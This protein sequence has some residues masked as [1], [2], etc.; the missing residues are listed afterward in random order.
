MAARGRRLAWLLLLFAAV[1][2]GLAGC[3]TLGYYAQ[4]VGGHL[5]LMRRARPVDEWLSD[6]ATPAKLRER[7]LLT[8]QIRDFAVKELK[9]P[10]NRSYR[11]YADLGRGS[12]VWN[13]VATPELSLELKRWCFPV[14]GC[15]G[16]RGYFDRAAAEALAKS[17]KD[18]GLDVNVYGVPAYSTLGW[19]NW[20]GGDP[21]LNTFIDWPEAQLARLVF[22]ELAHQVAYAAGDTTF[23]E[24]FA[25]AVERLGGERWRRQRG[26]SDAD[27]AA[28]DRRRADFRALSARTRAALEA[29]Y[30]SDVSDAHKRERKAEIFAA[31]RAELARLKAESWGG[32][33][34]YDA[35][36][37]RANN[38]TLGVQAAYD[39]LV[40]A[41]EK[42]FEREGRDFARLHAEARRLAA[43]PQAERR[44]TLAAISR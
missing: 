33:A 24:S 41:F 32:Y 29:L 16:Y 36:A 19:T 37:Q 23:N 22:H 14:L 8:Q 31:M 5:D 26:L 18:E 9:L 13:V 43:L 35:W 10:D 21:L 27:D 15:V 20:I 39:E 40:P 3:S 1:G 12:A 17:L 11:S 44:D 25:T 34:G 7:L 2:A 28:F 4:S 6:S 42:L 38:A 30:K